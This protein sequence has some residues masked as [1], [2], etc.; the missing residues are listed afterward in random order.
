LYAFLTAGRGYPKAVGSSEYDVEHGQRELEVT[1]AGVGGL[2][3]KQLLVYLDGRKAGAVT[4][5]SSG[6]AHREWDT[7]HGQRVPPSAA[8][9][10]VEVR[11]QAGTVVL[12]GSYKREQGD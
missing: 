8:G 6:R 5:S 11:T 9:G 10:K 12:S 3:G 2:A 7:E 1:M 4:V